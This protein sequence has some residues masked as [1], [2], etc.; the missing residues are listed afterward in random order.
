MPALAEARSPRVAAL[1]WVS[2]QNLTSLQIAPVCAPETLRYHQ[3][4]VVPQLS[5]TVENIGL[6]AEPNLE[7][8][9]SLS[10]D[11][12]VTP[13]AL[14]RIGPQL[15][16]IAPQV[17]FQ[18]HAAFGDIDQRHRDQ[19]DFGLY[20]LWDLA[21]ALINAGE[22]RA[23]LER[24]IKQQ[25]QALAQACTRIRTQ[26]QGKRLYVGT[27][28]GRRRALIFTPGSLFDAVLTRSGLENAW[29]QPGSA[30]G[31][32]TVPIDAIGSDPEAAFV[33]VGWPN[34]T[35]SYLASGD[36]L[37]NSLPAVRRDEMIL[38]ENTLFYGGVPSAT[39]FASLLADGL[40]AR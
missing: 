22:K 25:E 20:Q 10:P 7:M 19:I 14:K 37:L 4:V 23:M 6:R 11:L 9:S 36:L 26:W 18:P 12:I 21:R 17:Q 2:A 15:S 38:L 27:L 3:L 13:P 32:S 29:K 39:R 35:R 31:H 8:L 34:E 24:S 33:S 40:E 16:R 1:D 30:Y 28:V 5:S